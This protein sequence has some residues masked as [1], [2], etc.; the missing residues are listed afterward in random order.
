M[1]LDFSA[2]SG[3]ADYASGQGYKH[4]RIEARNSSFVMLILS[5]CYNVI[6]TIGVVYIV[7]S[8][9]KFSPTAVASFL[10]TIAIA[11]YFSQ[12]S[13]L[14][15]WIFVYVLYF[16]ESIIPTFKSMVKKILIGLPL[17]LVAPLIKVVA[18][19]MWLGT[20]SI[21]ENRSYMDGE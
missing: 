6:S 21:I 18:N 15:L 10:S 20:D 16:W 7:V 13:N 19:L 1:G 9:K 8:P 4:L 14:I 11:L 3:T 12:I 2:M 5:Y 17:I